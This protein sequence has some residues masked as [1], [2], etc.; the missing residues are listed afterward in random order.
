MSAETCRLRGDIPLL[1][2]PGQVVTDLAVLTAR[3]ADLMNDWV[4]EASRLRELLASIFPALER[5]LDCS[6]RAAL[7]LLTRFQTPAAIR[8]AGEP[9]LAAHLQ[10]QGVRAGVAQALT[11]KAVA[12]AAGQTIALPAETVTAPLI[13]R[14]ARQLLDLDREAKDLTKQITAIFR[15]HP[16][17][18]IIES[19]PGLGPVLGAEFLAGINGDLTAFGRPAKL[20]AFAGLAP[21]PRDSGRISGNFR[22]PER[23]HRGLRRVFFMAALCPSMHQGQSKTFYQ[24]KR[25]EGKHHLQALIALA[26]RLVDVLWALLRDNRPFTPAAPDTAAFQTAA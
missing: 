4:R 26:R 2:Q 5:S 17:A 19:L 10:D 6:T 15:T 22:K 7:T 25:A 24:R 11:A 13:A 18:A 9:G 23:Y 14:L 1:C 12:A 20:A 21:T 3:R 8:A 16:Q